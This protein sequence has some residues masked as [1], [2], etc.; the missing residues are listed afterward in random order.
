VEIGVVLCQIL[1]KIDLYNLLIFE[2][3]AYVYLRL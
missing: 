3:K 2:L 1:Y